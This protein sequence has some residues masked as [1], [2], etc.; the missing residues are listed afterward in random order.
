MAMAELRRLPRR[1]RDSQRLWMTVFV[2]DVMLDECR[3]W[4][5]SMNDN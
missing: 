4:L 5:G 2:L 3:C 1:Q